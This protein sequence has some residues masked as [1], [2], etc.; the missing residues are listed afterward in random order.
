LPI[1]GR[2]FTWHKGDGV[3]MSRL[4]RFFLSDKWCQKWPNC[5]QVAYLRGLSDHALL[6]LYVDDANWGPRLVR[7][8]KCWSEYQGYGDFVREKWGSFICHGW[9]GYVLQQKLKMMKAC[10]KEWHYQH[11]QK[12]DGKM[13]EVKNQIA[14]LD[15]KGE[16][17][18]LQDVEVRELHDLT[19]NLH[20]MARTQS[21]IQ[22]QK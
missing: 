11:T 21:S 1:C 12:M 7:M 14:I 16:L 2:L 22:W 13:L 10:L 4:D 6:L 18:D 8:L 3:S 9:D 5:I 15:A 20:V 19:V 17:S